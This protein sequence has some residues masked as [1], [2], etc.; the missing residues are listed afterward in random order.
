MKAPAKRNAGLAPGGFG[1]ATSDNANCSVGRP[2]NQ[3][4]SS[5]RRGGQRAP[6]WPKPPGA[7]ALDLVERLFRPL[8]VPFKREGE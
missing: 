1:E 2:P 5:Q 3:G 6:V 8:R 4:I 7:D